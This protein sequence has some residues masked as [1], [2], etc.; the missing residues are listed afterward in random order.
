MIR[1]ICGLA[2][3]V[4][5]AS[6]Q[7][8]IYAWGSYEE[9]VYALCHNFEDADLQETCAQLEEQV[10]RLRDH[11]LA[12][13]PGMYAQ[14]GYLEYLVGNH[15]VAAGHFNVEKT[16]YPESTVFMDGLLRRMAAQ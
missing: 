1:L 12:P 4:L 10:S 14:L 11:G 15:E 13:G 9:S 7:S 3:L 8:G 2:L 6:C 16:L 5:T